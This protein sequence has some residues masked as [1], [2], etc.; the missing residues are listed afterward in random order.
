MDFAFRRLSE[1]QNRKS[2]LCDLS[3]FAVNPAFSGIKD[4]FRATIQAT[5]FRGG[6]WLLTVVIYPHV[7]IPY[8]SSCAFREAAKCLPCEKLG[9]DDIF[10]HHT[11]VSPGCGSKW[12]SRRGNGMT[13][14]T[15][16]A[17]QIP[18]QI[19]F[20]KRNLLTISRHHKQ[21]SSPLQP[22]IINH[23]FINRNFNHRNIMNIWSPAEAGA[24]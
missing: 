16:I 14:A 9:S 20:I 7:I 24:R 12:I 8:R 22:S 4:P 21:L 19:L 13:T 6:S 10:Y 5:L 3:A 17:K 11:D 18:E 15:R 23:P 2:F 1:K